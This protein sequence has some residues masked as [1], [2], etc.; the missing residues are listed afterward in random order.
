MKKIVFIAVILVSLFAYV[1]STA[2]SVY[3][4]DT[5]KVTQKEDISWL[6]TG[7]STKVSCGNIN[8]IPKTIPKTTSLVVTFISIIAPVLLIV[9]GSLDFYKA[10]ASGND[11]NFKKCRN[12]FINRV[13]AAI[14]VFLIIVLVR[15]LIHTVSAAL[16]N[17]G[18][19]IVSCVDCFI[20]NKCK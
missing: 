17:G 18:N 3:A 14:F 12:A 5:E 13:V 8:N 15:S 16:G 4:V 19:G 1:F 6:G 2:E 9:F 11:D 10:I 20:S 7:S